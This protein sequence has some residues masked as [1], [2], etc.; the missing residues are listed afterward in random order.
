MRHLFDPSKRR[1]VAQLFV[2][3]AIGVTAA[4]FSLS[5]NPWRLAARPLRPRPITLMQVGPR[6]RFAP[7]GRSPS[8][9]CSYDGLLKA[10]K[11]ARYRDDAPSARPVNM[12][13]VDDVTL[14]PIEWSFDLPPIGTTDGGG[15]QLVD[16]NEACSLHAYT[17]EEAC[18][19]LSAFG[20]LY[21]TGDSLGRHLHTA[22]LMILRNRN[23]GAVKDYATTDDCRGE[24]LIND[25]KLCRNRLTVDTNI[26][27]HVCG[28]AAQVAWSLM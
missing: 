10:I 28:N 4:S 7:N 12:S 23:D 17:Q 3:V 27:E 20:G 21:S 19:L 14:R 18:E 1:R 22:L 26:E 8:Q 13:R 15:G 2:L 11:G 5:S 9:S 24:H 6:P 16:V 25:G